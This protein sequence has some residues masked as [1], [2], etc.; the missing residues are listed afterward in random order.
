[1]H[2][3]NLDRAEKLAIAYLRKHPQDSTSW[4]V[5][6]QVLRTREQHADEERILRRG[7]DFTGAPRLQFRLAQI[8]ASTGKLEEAMSVLDAFT[9]EQLGSLL[10]GP[11][12]LGI[13]PIES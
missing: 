9:K 4:D 5:W 11:S 1:M 8:L 13:V 12:P 3:G 7:V 6:S 2:Q 10:P